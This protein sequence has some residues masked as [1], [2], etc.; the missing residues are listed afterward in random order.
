MPQNLEVRLS[1]LPNFTGL[2]RFV[3]GIE[4]RM[5]RVRALQLRLERGAQQTS[6][7][8]NTVATAASGAAVINFFRQGSQAGVEF[9]ATLEQAEL[10]IAAVLKQFDRKGEYQNF[11]DAITEAGNA[12]DLLKAKAISSPASFSALVQ[13]FQGTV[14]PMTAANIQLRDQVDLI[15]N[16][17]QAL[18]GLG[19]RD[20]Q[21]LQ[22]TRALITGNINADAAAAKILGITAADITAAKQRGELFEFLSSKI[23]AFAEAGERGAGTLNTLKS[24]LGDAFEQRTADTATRLTDKLKEFYASATDFVQ[25]PTFTALFTTLNDKIAGIVEAGSWLVEWMADLGALSQVFISIGSSAGTALVPILALGAAGVVLRGAFGGLLS[26]ATPLRLLFVLLSGVDFVDAVRDMRLFN[27]EL[28]TVKTFAL[29]NWGQRIAAGLAAVGVAAAALAV[30]SAVIKGLEQAAI[31]RLEREDAIRQS[32]VDQTQELRDQVRAATTLAE[33]RNVGT[34]A[35]E[36]AQALVTQIADLEERQQRAQAN[37]DQAIANGADPFMASLSFRGLSKEEAD[38]LPIMK[39]QLVELY[40]TMKLLR[41]PQAVL[42]SQEQEAATKS[43]EA[44]VDELVKKLAELRIKWDEARLAQMA[45]GDRARELLARREA[46][47]AEL[48]ALGQ[49]ANDPRNEAQRLNLQIR[50]AAVTNDITAAQKELQQATE[51]TA[52][53]AQERE[54]YLLETQALQAEAAGNTVL[55]EQL[56]E[57]ISELEQIRDL[58]EQ[59]RDMV[60]SRLEAERA[61]SAEKRAQLA[62]EQELSNRIANV[63]AALTVVQASPLLTDT[64]KE[65]AQRAAF[66]D[67]NRALEERIQLLQRQAQS[68]SGDE[69]QTI[70]QRIDG[71]RAEQQAIEGQLAAIQQLTPR[72]GAIAGLVD[73]LNTIP[74]LAER[75]RQSLGS[76]AQSL[77]QGIGRALDGLF[78][79]TMKWGDAFREIGTSV[80]RGVL[81][82]LINLASQWIV[83]QL[84]M[85][86][87]G[88]A[89]QAAQL[90]ALA[91]IAAAQA[92]LWAP[93]A[94]AASIATLG[95][96]AVEGAAMAKAAIL[97][98]AIGFATGGLVSGPGTGTSDSIAARLSNGEFV[99]PAAAVSHYG[100][101][102]M[103]AIRNRTFDPARAV[104]SSITR[105]AT[106]SQGGGYG[107][108]GAGGGMDPR[109]F[110]EA[111]AGKVQFVAVNSDAEARRIQQKGQ[112]EGDIVI[113]VERNFGI[114]RKR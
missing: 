28:G 12:I 40:R 26:L 91:P 109:A 21:I 35:Q 59:H 96:A 67:V 69:A 105:P 82:S 19:I 43:N 47:Y 80:V 102:F 14:G 31:N 13:A 29:A 77:Q 7:L 56:R 27:R 18:A 76:I 62:I 74:T 103:E 54:L 58:G 61:V 49:D 94:T 50:I 6:Q 64:Q 72:Q 10:G 101:D 110:V 24:N 36:Q 85:A 86:V 51:D 20:E 44:A 17:S 2:D 78:T 83:Q 70:Q 16:M 57:Q 52:R 37:R 60:E 1:F 15:V 89:L 34:S 8:L 4:N 48:D 68:A 100:A 9:N 25:S 81:D 46:L 63:R 66:D 112:A 75:A 23:A 114:R 39:Q 45:P 95:A 41:D 33:L 65:A 42:A 93:A 97:T 92:A 104:A 108:G 3:R 53:A 73:Y 32:M 88:K 22:E 5:E 71:Y 79:R 38:R 87:M 107:G 30:G 90:A 111:F 55:A 99:Q 113:M 106:A 84:I 11:D 98:S